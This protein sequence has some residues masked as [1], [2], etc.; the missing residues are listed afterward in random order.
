[1]GENYISP[2]KYKL[3]QV[4]ISFLFYEVFSLYT[5]IADGIQQLPP[6]EPK[7]QQVEYLMSITSTS[8][9]SKNL[10]ITLSTFS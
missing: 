1:M 6:I 7:W 3:I 10:F 9:S 5:S 2:I 8:F 4:R